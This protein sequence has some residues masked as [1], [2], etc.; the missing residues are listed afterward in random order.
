M[1]RLAGFSSPPP[2]LAVGLCL[3]ILQ[4]HLINDL[5]TR[6]ASPSKKALVGTVESLTD[7]HTATAMT[8]HTKLLK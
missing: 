6:D 1:D 4:N 3:T 8:P 5:S 7:H 2:V